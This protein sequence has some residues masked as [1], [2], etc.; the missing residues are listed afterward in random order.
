MLSSVR[1]ELRQ[2]ALLAAL[3]ALP[4]AQ[5][6]VT[7]R[8]EAD[9]R[10]EIA[11][12]RFDPARDALSLRGGAPPLS[13]QRGV[14]MSALGDGRYAAEVR[15]DAAPYGGQPVPHKFR[16]EKPGQGADDGWEPGRN[17][18]ALLDGPAPRIARLFGAEPPAPPPR[19][20]GTVLNFDPGPARHALA[21]PVWVWLP[22]GYDS[23]VAQRYPVLYLLDGQ[24]VFDGSRA[25][26]EWQVDEAAQRLVLAG[27]V[28]PLIVV[29]VPSGRDRID[30]YTPTAG[31]MNGAR[32]GGGGPAFAR[33]LLEDLKPAIDK[34]FR[35]R[36][37]AASTA[38]GGSS[39][40]GLFSLWLAL[41]HG[42]QVGAALVVS[43][44]VWWDEGF[45]VRD[46]S[47]WL[48]GSGTRPR[49]WLDIGGQEGEGA[50]PAVRRLHEALLS[51]GWTAATLSYLE[52][53]DARHD[54]LSWAA[55]V[56]GMLKF[57]HGAAVR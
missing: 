48:P 7:A 11:A 25:G 14:A 56:E 57:L 9:L 8:F 27:T 3:L 20:T 4:A 44:S 31:P 28:A 12:G 42:D 49:L 30:E 15:F 16:I 6:Q 26:A 23:A 55:R 21:R 1:S 2:L 46:A 33:Y 34:R 40:G 51:R 50:V 36:P 43:P 54:E 37:E 19:I 29:A 41:H 10:A 22:P 53:P 52:V 32:R 5:A 38:I 45:A 18:A 47:Q 35:T 24:N 39:L 13:W 17:R